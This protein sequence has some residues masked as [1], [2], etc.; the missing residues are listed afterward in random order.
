M[1]KWWQ[2][3]RSGVPNFCAVALA[4]HDLGW[5]GTDIQSTCEG[6]SAILCSKKMFTKLNLSPLKTKMTKAKLYENLGDGI[7]WLT[8]SS[9]ARID[10]FLLQ[11]QQLKYGTASTASKW[12]SKVVKLTGFSQLNCTKRLTS[13]PDFCL[14]RVEEMMGMLL[15]VVCTSKVEL[16]T[17]NTIAKNV[18]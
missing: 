12:Q 13:Q 6:T 15:D 7:V 17:A 10:S 5:Q 2:V 14:S 4:L 11:L 1:E 18:G 9:M 8:A 16:A 3:S